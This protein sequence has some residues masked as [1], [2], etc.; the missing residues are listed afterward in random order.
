M[1]DKSLISWTD[2]G[3]PVVTGCEHV[4]EGCDRCWAARLT[5]GRLRKHPAYAGLAVAGRFT[6]E[7]RV[8][9]G[10]LDEPRH[11]RKPRRIFVSPNADLFNRKVPEEFIGGVWDT[12][13]VTP[14]HI[15]QVLTK[16]HGRLRALLREWQQAGWLWRRNDLGWCGPLDGPLRNVHVGVSAENQYWADRRLT[17]LADTPAAVRWASLEPLLGPVNLVDVM[18]CLDWVV[19][20]G[21]SGPG[22]RPM[23]VGWLEEIVAQARLAGVPVWV[24]Q[25][26]GPRADR[27]GR[28][29]DD[30]WIREFPRDTR[31]EAA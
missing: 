13:A 29:P 7:V 17:A 18:P 9:P 12:M 27:Q 10:R 5:S 11:W 6:G 30:L 21:E 25:D 23:D 1:A 3:W 15:Y 14:Q 22:H 28:I 19:V 31:L 16:R 24:K 20:G 4:S 2:S 26:S 8:F